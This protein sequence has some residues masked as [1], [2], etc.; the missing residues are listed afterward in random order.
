MGAFQL[1]SSPWAEG[2][3]ASCE[4]PC[5]ASSS[6]EGQSS[7]AGVEVEPYCWADTGVHLV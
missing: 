1:N 5:T 6:S 2:G 7:L 3:P 4:G